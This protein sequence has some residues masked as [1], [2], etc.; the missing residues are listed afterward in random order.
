MFTSLHSFSF[1]FSKRLFFYYTTRATH[2]EKQLYLYIYLN[3]RTNILVY[4]NKVIYFEQ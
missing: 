1:D 3:K 2:L 4:K